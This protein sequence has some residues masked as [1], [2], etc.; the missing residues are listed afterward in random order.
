MS[1]W[2][3]L[4]YKLPSEPTALRVYVWRKL[5]RLG[6]IL[7]QDAVWVL[8]GSDRAME[9]FRWLAVEIVEM[10]GE[11]ALWESLP[12]LTGIEKGLV[13]EFRDQADQA[14]AE[15]LEQVGQPEYDL[16]ALSRQYQQLSQRDYF[17]SQMGVK[18]RAALLSKR[19][20][21]K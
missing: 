21:G 9:Q 7:F 11:A 8:P 14:F 16:E 3:L 5:K 10:G 17:R 19:G 18:A 12:L 20:A 4:H 6:A 15:L 13:Q 2:L 1:K